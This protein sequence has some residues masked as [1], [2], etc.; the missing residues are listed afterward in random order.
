ME[1]LTELKAVLEAVHPAETELN[2]RPVPQPLDGSVFGTR[3][4]TG[5]DCDVV[6]QNLL[7]GNL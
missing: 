7:I 4:E 3:Y 6:Y 5:V 2:K 1:D